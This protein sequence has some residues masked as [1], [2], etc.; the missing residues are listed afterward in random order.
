M[1]SVVFMRHLLI[2]TQP[3]KTGMTDT[4]LKTVKGKAVYDNV[5]NSHLFINVHQRGLPP[6]FQ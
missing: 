5:N 4:D 6:L 1:A 3:D 2:A